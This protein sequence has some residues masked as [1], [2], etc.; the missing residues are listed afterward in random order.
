MPKPP[1]SDQAGSAPGAP[2]A[3]SFEVFCATYR[4][5]VVGRLIQKGSAPHDAEDLAHDVLLAAWL[6]QCTGTIR[7]LRSLIE[8]ASDHALIDSWRKRETRR[9]YEPQLTY[10]YELMQAALPSVESAALQAERAC[11]LLD[12]RNKLPEAHQAY[13]LRKEHGLDY[14]EI[15]RVMGIGR[16]KASKLVRVAL[17]ELLKAGVEGDYL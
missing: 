8:R 10:D 9:T 6:A 14:S 11:R 15:A 5:H 3:E 16:N 4:S 2:A 13:L 7:D 17:E 1:T 12:L